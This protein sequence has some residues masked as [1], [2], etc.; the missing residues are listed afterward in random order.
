MLMVQLLWVI[1]FLMILS[2]NSLEVA[3]YDEVTLLVLVSVFLV[4]QHWKPR[5]GGDSIGIVTT[6][7]SGCR[8]NILSGLLMVSDVSNETWQGASGLSPRVSY[9]RPCNLHAVRKFLAPT[10]SQAST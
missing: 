3:H 6:Y 2:N 1:E 5:K 8:H 9:Q 4:Y 7:K 10:Y